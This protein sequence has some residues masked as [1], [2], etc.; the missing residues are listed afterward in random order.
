MDPSFSLYFFRKALVCGQKRVQWHRH[1]K[2]YCVLSSNCSKCMSA[3]VAFGV[4]NLIQNWQPSIRISLRFVYALLTFLVACNCPCLTFA[5]LSRTHGSHSTTWFNLA[6]GDA[7][8]YIRT[9]IWILYIFSY[10]QSI[11]CI[12]NN[13]TFILFCFRYV[14]FLFNFIL[15][16]VSKV[17]YILYTYIETRQKNRTIFQ[18]KIIFILPLLLERFCSIFRLFTHDRIRNFFKYIIIFILHGSHIDFSNTH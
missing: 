16:G 15:H 11:R 10:V 7:F 3:T 6:S 2:E 4:H 9:Q 14:Q 5:D 1:P 17:C 8:N 12:Q 18:L 13:L